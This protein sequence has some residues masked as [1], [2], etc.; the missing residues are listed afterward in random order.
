MIFEKLQTP[1]HFKVCKSFPFG[2]FQTYLPGQHFFFFWWYISGME[3]TDVST[4]LDLIVCCSCCCSVIKS[5][6]TLCDPMDCSIPGSSV[7]HYLL[8]F[9]QI[10]IHWVSD[11]ISSSASLFS[12]YLQSFLVSIRIFSNESSHCIRWPKY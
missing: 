7:F 9:A 3:D 4:L 8:E 1:F 12:F 11:T 2:G 10:H 6:A 5:C